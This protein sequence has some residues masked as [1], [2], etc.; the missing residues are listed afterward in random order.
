MSLGRPTGVRIAVV[1]AVVLAA[2]VAL[3]VVRQGSDRVVLVSRFGD[4]VRL[5]PAGPSLSFLPLAR[6]VYVGRQAAAAVFEVPVRLALPGGASLPARITLRLGSDGRLPISAAVVRTSGWDA[7][8]AAWFEPRLGISTDG[9]AA[10]LAGSAAWREIFPSAR[11]TGTLDVGPRFAG[12]FSPV[13]VLAALVSAEPEPELVRAAARDELA[14]RAPARGRLVVIGLDALDWQLIDEL[15]VRGVMPNL[16]RLLGRS[17]QATVRMRPPL[18]SPLIWTTIAT[19]QPP[20]VHG[21]L[22]FVD[23]D[24]E[25]GQPK[26]ITSAARKATALWEMAAAA[27]RT[28]AVIGWWATYPASAPPGAAVYSDRLTEQLMGLEEN[29]PGLAD[30]LDAAER[31]R[32]LVV[33]GSQITPAMLAPLLPVT[34]AELDAVPSGP[35]AWDHPIGGAARLMAA[36]LTVERLTEAELARGTDVVLAYLEGTDTV[37]HLF[38][39]C[40]PP[41]LS[42]C[43]PEQARR[44]APLVDRYHA[45]VDDWL[46]RI[47][48][49]LRPE[50]T[51]V[52]LSDHG[53]TWGGD[54]PNVASG[55]HTPTAVYW[56]RPD[57][58]LIVAGPGV[59]A[60]RARRRLEPL[61]VLPGLLAL[62]GLPPGDDLPGR[63]PGWLLRAPA[64]DL[65][66]VRWASLA[67]VTRAQTVELPPE[68]RE[69]EL[70]KLRALGYLGGDDSGGAAPPTPAAAAP[71]AE[72]TADVGRLEAR[73][74]HNLGLTRADAGDLAAAETAFR[75]AIAADPTYAPPHY[76]FAR[77]LR[78]TARFDE[79]DAEL[80]RSVDLGLGD[81]ASAL[82]RVAGE[83]RK[84]KQPERAGAVL[85]RAAERFP[86]SGGLWLDLGTLAGERGDFAFARQCLER[87]VA[88]LP[89]EPVARRNL[90]AACLQL[91]DEACAR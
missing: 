62:A 78:L 88:L 30:P 2:L 60:D 46:G 32:R 76:A 23:Q 56:H 29:R 24:P 83:Y 41:A 5:L 3:S 81:P 38:G 63:T 90:A 59:V 18:L 6:R 50:D 77:V 66:A 34:Q 75:A 89:G 58:L 17:A 31:A 26:P 9:A 43:P 12:E 1:V 36:T 37:G 13:T 61:D 69:E 70:A 85:A 86:D 42:S 57:A 74:Q 16:G 49:Q 45:V 35:A 21:V 28:S 65:P 15:T 68:A 91:G 82:V 27:G 67:P 84:L 64:T 10:L 14:R 72:P 52:I 48:G 22:D 79:A 47:V 25:T 4:E 33:R 51:L 53:F 54:R 19:G 8:W 80:W 55:A 39:A 40:R 20:D 73:R 44:F 11:P 71:A 87:A 7:T